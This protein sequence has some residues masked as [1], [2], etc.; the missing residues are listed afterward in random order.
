REGVVFDAWARLQNR[1]DPGLVTRLCAALDQL[2][3]ARHWALLPFF[4]LS[5]AETLDRH[6]EAAT[7][8][9]L[10]GRAADVAEATGERWC[11]PEIL[12]LRARHA[13]GGSAA[14]GLLR[15]SLARAREQGALLWERRAAADLARLLRRQGQC[16]AAR[17]VVASIRART[18]RGL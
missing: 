10:L 16:E 2:E 15:Q 18:S 1:R 3:A 5:A 8:A 17:G 13:G 11:E 7:A 14:L 12:R 9:G 6:G 4:L